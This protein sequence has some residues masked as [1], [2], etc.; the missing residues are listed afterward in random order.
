MSLV[1]LRK[2]EIFFVLFFVDLFFLFGDFDFLLP[3]NTF[4]VDEN[5]YIFVRDGANECK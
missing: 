1:S 5:G 3:M 4:G 2:A